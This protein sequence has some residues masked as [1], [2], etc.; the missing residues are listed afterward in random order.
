MSKSN[1]TK[2]LV[3]VENLILLVAEPVR[4]GEGITL[5]LDIYI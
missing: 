4:T 3:Y 1:A 2:C 5:N